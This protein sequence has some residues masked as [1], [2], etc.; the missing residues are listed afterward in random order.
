MYAWRAS[1]RGR[2]HQVGQWQELIGEHQSVLHRRCLVLE[3]LYVRGRP[4]SGLAVK[5]ATRTD[6]SSAREC[7]RTIGAVRAIQ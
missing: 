4:A 5:S 2:S 6:G 3:A 1:P 7:G